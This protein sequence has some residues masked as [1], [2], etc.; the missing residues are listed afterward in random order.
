M[1]TASNCGIDPHLTRLRVEQ[2]KDFDRQHG[3]MLRPVTVPREGT[4]R[5]FVWGHT[6]IGEGGQDGPSGSRTRSGNAASIVPVMATADQTSDHSL[7]R[8]Q[9]GHWGPTRRSIVRFP[10]ERIGEGEQRHWGGADIEQHR[11]VWKA[12]A[13]ALECDMDTIEDTTAQPKEGCLGSGFVKETVPLE[14]KA[15]KRGEPGS[16]YS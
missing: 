3:H 9:R 13:A 2:A 7:R 5:G 12:G 8:R 15:G 16:E 14:Y 10:H 11:T 1:P 4:G 6:M